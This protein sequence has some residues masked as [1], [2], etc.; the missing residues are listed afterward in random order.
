HRHERCT[1]RTPTNTRRYRSAAN[2][3]ATLGHEGRTMNDERTMSEVVMKMIERLRTWLRQPV[4]GRNRALAHLTLA[5]ATACRLPGVASAAPSFDLQVDMSL[6]GAAQ[7]TVQT[8]AVF[9]CL[10]ACLEEESFTCKALDF[11]ASSG[12][13]RLSSVTGSGAKTP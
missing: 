4:R 13:C 9:Q 3:A 5:L 7:K 6:R 10:A 1:L 8:D 2:G 11:D 12:R